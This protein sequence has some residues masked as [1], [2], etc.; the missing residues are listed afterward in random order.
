MVQNPYCFALLRDEAT[1]STFSL[2]LIYFFS[3]RLKIQMFHRCASLTLTDFV[4][5]ASSVL[6]PWIPYF[7]LH[8]ATSFRSILYYF[9]YKLVRSMS[10][11]R[12]SCTKHLVHYQ[13]NSLPAKPIIYVTSTSYWGRISV[14]CVIILH[15]TIVTVAGY[16]IPFEHSIKFCLITYWIIILPN[17]I[18]L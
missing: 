7:F 8:W 5:T 17:C 9:D 1:S 15:V 13:S 2:I 6:H 16:L 18:G 11:F 12:C 10:S 4:F 3:F 14:P